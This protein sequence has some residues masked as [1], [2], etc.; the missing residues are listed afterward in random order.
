LIV[1]LTFRFAAARYARGELY[2]FRAPAL[3]VVLTFMGFSC[4]G[5]W[6]AAALP[7]FAAYQPQI[8]PPALTV[9]LTFICAP[10]SG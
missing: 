8:P 2:T 7:P 1:V 10:L 6:D 9:V 3:I 5:W 4:L